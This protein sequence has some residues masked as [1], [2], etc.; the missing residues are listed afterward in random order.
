[1]KRTSPTVSSGSTDE[2]R[3]T[4]DRRVDVLGFDGC[5]NV[6]EALMRARAAVEAADV[7][8]DV[9]LVRVRGDDD[10]IR[11]R[12]LGSPTVRV[13]GVDVER[14]ATGRLDFGL[15]CRVY[16]IDGRLEGAP[17]VDWIVTALRGRRT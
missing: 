14:S 4:T 10:A 13:D 3:P 9:R 11:L 1:M 16:S 5:P 8:A 2:E 15:Q 6:D 17:P 7:R 12:F